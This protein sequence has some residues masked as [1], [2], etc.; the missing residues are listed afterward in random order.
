MEVMFMA[1]DFS[2]NQLKSPQLLELWAFVLVALHGF[3]PR[4]CGL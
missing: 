4:T 1:T 3:E 2:A